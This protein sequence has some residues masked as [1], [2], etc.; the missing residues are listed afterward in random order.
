MTICLLSGDARDLKP[1][2]AAK[3][4][5]LLAKLKVRA[6]EVADSGKTPML[7]GSEAI[8][9]RIRKQA[10]ERFTRRGFDGGHALDDWLAA[11]RQ[12]L[13]PAAEIRE[14]AGGYQLRIA[15]PGIDDADVQ[16]VCTSDEFFVT[17]DRHEP[18]DRNGM[19]STLLWSEFYSGTV[20]RLVSVPRPVEPG[21]VTAKLKH[22]ILEITAPFPKARK[23]SKKRKNKKKATVK[24]TA[25][26]ETKSKS[27]GKKKK[28]QK[29]AAKRGKG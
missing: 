10:Y 18:G 29:S 21:K 15:L 14:F 2:P 7:V 28:K 6:L 12:I 11:E 16:V 27:I 24:K 23:S 17:A 13:Q 8:L 19:S 22:G 9:D 4:D 25:D 20:Y 5:G 3:G 1:E 26:K